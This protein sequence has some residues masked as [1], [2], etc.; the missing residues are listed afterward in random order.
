MWHHRHRAE[1]LI[2][3]RYVRR[4][5]AEMSLARRFLSRIL[6]FLYRKALALP[7]RDLS[8]GFRMYR[9]DVLADIGLPEAEGLDALPEMTVKA[10]SQGWRIAEVPFWYQGARPFT[11]MLMVRLGLGYLT[12]LGRA[13][14]LRNSVKAADYDHRAFDSWI[15]LQRY[16]QRSRFRIIQNFVAD[17]GW[18]L[19]IGCGSSRIVQTLPRVVATDLAELRNW[20]FPNVRLAQPTAEAFARAYARW[21]E[22]LTMDSPLGWLHKVAVN[23]VRPVHE[24]ATGRRHVDGQR[25]VGR[26]G[27]PLQNPGAAQNQ[28]TMAQRRHRRT[29]VEEMPHDALHLWVVAQIL[30]RPAAWDDQGDVIGRVDVG[31]GQVGRPRMTRLLGVRVEAVDEV[32]YDELQL[33]RG[34]CGDV[35]L[36]AL[37][38]KPLVRVE[39]LQV[40]SRVAGDDEYLGHARPPCTTMYLATTVR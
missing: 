25:R 22:P 35:H 21:P 11:R 12:T 36:V 29:V 14:A 33:L 13:F 5:Y 40:F 24:R 23:D 9:S 31:E 28:R 38:Q 7:Y 8:S 6:N 18:V 19:D 4:A 16:W 2:A 34:R 30:R 10:Y 15:P 27:P 1:V 3:S 32:V 20:G 26:R 17:E 37:F 39:H